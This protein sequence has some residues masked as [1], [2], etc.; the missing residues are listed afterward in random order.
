M[1][2]GDL[3]LRGGLEKSNNKRKMV[4]KAGM[5][6]SCEYLANGNAVWVRVWPG[7]EFLRDMVAKRGIRNKISD[8][9]YY[10]GIIYRAP[11]W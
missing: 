2:Y 10:S 9:F 3:W 4:W 7:S 8:F 11:I 5:E 6:D 1:G